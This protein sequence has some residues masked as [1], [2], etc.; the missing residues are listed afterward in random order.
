VV[1]INW[2]DYVFNK[3]YKLI[4]LNELEKFIALN[5]HLPNIPAAADVEKNGL[6]V[7]AVQAK[8][9]E[10]IEELTLYILELNKR[11]TELEKERVKK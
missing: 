8:Q 9:M 7:G 2:A 5:K 11:I 10:K 6:D 3:S 1:E 4:P